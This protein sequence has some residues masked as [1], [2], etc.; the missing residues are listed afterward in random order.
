MTHEEFLSLV[1]KHLA[2]RQDCAIMVIVKTPAGLEIQTNFMD[3]VISMGILDI[4]KMITAVQ[5]DHSVRSPAG[6]AEIRAMT[7]EIKNT[8]E[9]KKTEVN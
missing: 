9:G 4:A 5:F 3:F 2:E 1:H 7:D 6:K 8:S